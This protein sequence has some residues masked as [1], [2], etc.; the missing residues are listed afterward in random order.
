SG[1]AAEDLWSTSC[2]F[3]DLDGDG[4]L[5]LYVARYLDFSLDNHKYCGL[6]E[7]GYRV[8]CEPEVY[9][10][11]DD[12]LYWNDQARGAGW[13]EAPLDAA[14]SRG[15]GLGV[16][17]A[18]LTGD[19]LL[20]IY[21]ANDRTPNVLWVNLGGRRLEERGLRSGVALSAEGRARAGMGVDAAD[22]DGDGLAELVV[23]NF[24]RE[25]NALF[26]SLAPGLFAD[27]ASA[28]GLA[29]PSFLPLGFGVNFWDVD[30][31]GDQ[32]LFAANGHVTDNIELYQPDLDH[33]QPDQLFLNDGSGKFRLAGDEWVSDLSVPRVS[34]GSAVGDLDQDGRLDLVVTHCGGPA[35]V[36]WNRAPLTARAVRFRLVGTSAAR[37]PIG[38]SLRLEFA[39]KKRYQ[40]LRGGSSYLSQ[41]STWIHGGLGDAP[42]ADGVEIE[43]RGGAREL[44]SGAPAG[45]RVILKEGLA[46]PL[47][48][49]LELD[50]YSR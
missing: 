34:R 27:D 32:D 50:R 30:N 40:I 41:S 43:W 28:A 16:V 17:V 36:F 38:A 25:A 8:Y 6:L 5:D 47:L 23:T 49:R 7:P 10:G 33:A 13:T 19:G 15:K 29:I 21:V 46:E 26:R 9:N 45:S 14:E 12:A 20:D 2:S 42:A 31:D 11:V 18:D 44:F 35:I 3:A 37:E 4:F 1:P 24:S 39:G 22:I 48:L